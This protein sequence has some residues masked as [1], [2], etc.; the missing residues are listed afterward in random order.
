MASARWQAWW[1]FALKKALSE[2]D[3]WETT[4]VPAKDLESLTSRF[5]KQSRSW[6]GNVWKDWSW[7]G[8]LFI[9]WKDWSWKGCLLIVLKRLMLKRMS[10]HISKKNDPEKIVWK[11]GGYA[12]HESATFLLILFRIPENIF[13]QV[14]NVTCEQNIL[15]IC[16]NG[17][18]KLTYPWNWK[19]LAR[20]SENTPC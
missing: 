14:K 4:T 7:K 17:W 5:E 11:T 9:F 20:H 6:K 19:H 13:L 12:L 2:R 18:T 10:F 3:E 16:K 15:T 8:C 1:L